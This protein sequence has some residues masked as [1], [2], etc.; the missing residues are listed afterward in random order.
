V[1]P[2]SGASEG[3]DEAPRRY[4]TLSD[5]FDQTEEMQGFEYSGV[6]LTAYDEPASVEQALSEDCW[7]RAMEAEMQS[8]EENKT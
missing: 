5:L 3:T 6:C 7:K 1:S 8:I 2:P 4:R